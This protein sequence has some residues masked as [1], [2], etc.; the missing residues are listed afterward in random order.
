M[1]IT[2][3]AGALAGQR[4]P[5]VLVKSATL[6]GNSVGGRGNT[7]WYAGGQPI[8][9]SAN[10]AGVNGRA[11]TTALGL[12]GLSRQDPASGL[13]YAGRLPGNLVSNSDRTPAVWL[14]D[15]L[16]E[17]SGLSVTSTALQSIT[18]AALP[19]RSID[20]TADG[21][22]VLAALEWST[23]PGAGTP[24]ATLTYTNQAGTTGRT[25]VMSTT[26]SGSQVG[27][28]E[29][30]RL[31]GGDTGIRAPT[32]LQFSATRTSG[33]V[34]LVLFRVLACLEAVS[35]V[36]AGFDPI[37]GGFQKVPAGAVIQPLMFA[38]STA[39][40]TTNMTFTYIEAHG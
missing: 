3:Q 28:F 7:T 6:S 16:W 9:A 17:N 2:T 12:P 29:V 10:A 27:L 24:T 30:F 22:G 4:P 25:A 38:T 20:L 18:P 11:V 23:V 19:A 32:G 26:N 15:R 40:A 5:A 37:T 14:I 8:A 39:T 31:A 1:A 35:A 33:T 36:S 21:D 34:H 13:A